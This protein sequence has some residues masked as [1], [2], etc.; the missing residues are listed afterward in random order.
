MSQDRMDPAGFP[1]VKGVTA[2]N[3]GKYN[4]YANVFVISI[5]PVGSLLAAYVRR[6]YLPLRRNLG[7]Q[8]LSGMYRRV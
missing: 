2:L 4:I 6:I 3:E 7:Y 8:K 1:R 5:T